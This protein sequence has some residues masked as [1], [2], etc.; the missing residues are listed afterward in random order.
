M[1][2]RTEALLLLKSGLS[3]T[4]LFGSGTRDWSSS[5]QMTISWLYICPVQLLLGCERQQRKMPA[6][7]SGPRHQK[8]ITAISSRTFPLVSCCYILVPIRGT[9]LPCW[10]FFFFFYKGCKRRIFD[11]DYL[12]SLNSSHVELAPYGIKAFDETGIVS[13]DNVKTD[14]DIVVLATGFQV[15]NFLFLWKIMAE[16]D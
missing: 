12:E 15:H 3:N 11:P 2:D 14:F 7:T 16:K 13:S 10:S 9:T 5:S 6:N 8:S 4:F 1:I